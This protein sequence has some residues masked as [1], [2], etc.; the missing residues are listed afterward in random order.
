M[1]I[2]K[3]NSKKPTI[4]VITG[5]VT[6]VAIAT[7]TYFYFQHDNN[8]ISSENTKKQ[9]ESEGKSKQEFIENTNQDGTSKDS[10]DSNPSSDS[11]P[12]SNPLSLVVRPETD[13]TVTILTN[14]GSIASGNCT[15]TITNGDKNI[16]KTAPVIYQEV[17]SSCAGFSISSVDKLA[18]GTG[19]WEVTLSVAVNTNTYNTKTSYEAK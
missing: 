10:G 18:L 14:L 11:T 19:N 13:G 12:N 6:I 5:I 16:S 8:T 15:L 17:Y 3:T 9:K 1:K 2:N 4:L 7:G